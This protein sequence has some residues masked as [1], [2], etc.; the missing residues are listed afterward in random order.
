MAGPESSPTGSEQPEI[1][2][3]EEGTVQ[4]VDKAEFMAGAQDILETTA[5][6]NERIAGAFEANASDKEEAGKARSARE[7]HSDAA[8]YQARADEARA[9]IDKALQQRSDL[10]DRTSQGKAA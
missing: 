8:E 9:K 1:R 5:Q 6:R 4:D 7:A 10:Y 3:G 2:P